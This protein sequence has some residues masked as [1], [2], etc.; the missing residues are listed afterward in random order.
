[1]IIAGA[2]AGEAKEGTQSVHTRRWAPVHADKR[3]CRELH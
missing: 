3:R 2:S 1:M